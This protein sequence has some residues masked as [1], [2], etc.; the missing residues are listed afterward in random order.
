[1]IQDNK[2]QI[3]IQYF[4]R[5]KL[6]F[7]R[8]NNE[9]FETLTNEKICFEQFSYSFTSLVL[10]Q[11]MHHITSTKQTTRANIGQHYCGFA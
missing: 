10:E 5:N 11:P 7:S 4:T 6:A 3:T 2:V 1:M 9:E 8:A